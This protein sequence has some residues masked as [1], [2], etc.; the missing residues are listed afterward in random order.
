MYTGSGRVWGNGTM[1]SDTQTI[2]IRDLG[3]SA[4]LVLSPALCPSHNAE[5]T[6]LTVANTEQHSQTP[7]LCCLSGNIFLWRFL[8][9]ATC[10]EVVWNVFIIK[11]RSGLTTYDTVQFCVCGNES[12]SIMPKMILSEANK[13]TIF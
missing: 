6:R 1:R 5:S 3:L 8:L 10:C 13:Y 9:R 4:H 7:C 12:Q 11:F 2:Y